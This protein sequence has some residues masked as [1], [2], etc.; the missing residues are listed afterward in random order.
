MIID[1]ENLNKQTVCAHCE[2]AIQKE[3]A[4]VYLCGRTKYYFC[5]QEC[6]NQYFEDIEAFL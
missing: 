1:M 6:E 4:K 3:T 5:S 2:K